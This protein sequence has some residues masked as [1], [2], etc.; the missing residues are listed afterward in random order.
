M[1]DDDSDDDIGGKPSINLENQSD[2][3]SDE[4]NETELIGGLNDEN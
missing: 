2:S 1:E 4:K 3:D